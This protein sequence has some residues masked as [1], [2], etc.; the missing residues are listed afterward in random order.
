VRIDEVGDLA[1][2]IGVTAAGL[3]EEHR[4]FGVGAIEGAVKESL[5]AEPA[6][7]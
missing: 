3:L 1:K 5:N 7:R 4:S 2:Q 6:R